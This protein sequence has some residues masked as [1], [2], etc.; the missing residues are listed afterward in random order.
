M[1]LVFT[2]LIYSVKTGSIKVGYLINNKMVLRTCIYSYLSNNH[3]YMYMKYSG[4]PFNFVFCLY[5]F[6]K[7]IELKEN[8]F[9]KWYLHVPS[10]SY[11]N[12]LYIYI[13]ATH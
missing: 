6:K 3:R 13:Y 5:L 9:I 7:K 4:F 12:T 8:I 1:R 2:K 10:N 11:E